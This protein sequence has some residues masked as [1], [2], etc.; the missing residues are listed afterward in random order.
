MTELTREIGFWIIVFIVFPFT[1][2]N[3]YLSGRNIQA[4]LDVERFHKLAVSPW[5]GS[6]FLHPS[7]VVT[8]FGA[9]Q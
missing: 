9:G 3:K 5:R 1:D 8:Q 2:S 6:V 4:V 7:I